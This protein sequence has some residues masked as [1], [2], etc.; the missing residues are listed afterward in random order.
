MKRM[1]VYLQPV[2]TFTP[3]SGVGRHINGMVAELTKRPEWDVELLFSKQWLG[4]DG[5]LPKN[6]PLRNL[7]FRTFHLPERWIERA[8]KLV[9]YPN[10]D[11]LLLGFDF[12]YCPSD[13]A[14]PRTSIPNLVTIHDIH[15]LDPLYPD[16]CPGSGWNSQY[17]RW[18]RWVPKAF[19]TSSGI[20]TVSDFCKSRMES[21]IS[22]LTAPVSVVGNGVDRLFFDLAH[23]DPST[24]RRPGPWPYTLVIGGLTDRKGAK[25][26]L[27]VA[28]EL[29]SRSSELRIVVIGR[30]ETKWSLRAK[31]VANIIETGPVDDAIMG[32]YLRAATSLIF[33]SQYEGFGIP[34]VEAMAAGVPVVCSNSS[35]LPEVAGD[36]GCIHPAENKE[37]IT[38]ELERLAGNTVYRK[39][40]VVAGTSHA[41][42]FTWDKCV[43]RLLSA[44][45]DVSERPKK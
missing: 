5:S 42:K 2:R 41:K 3:C 10:I 22:P 7:P 37:A 1:L 39:Q 45:E 12:L 28:Q 43:D 38:S 44:M 20:L 6:S 24:C 33:L 25:A 11:R 13:T 35:S 15:P 14:F 21:L 8:W 23:R 16:Y 18:K 27:A 9:G 29:Q 34:I 4:P 40:K 36:A 17:G 19:E 26:T 30:S 32:E 31:D